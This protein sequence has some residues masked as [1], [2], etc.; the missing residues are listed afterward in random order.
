VGSRQQDAP[1]GLADALLLGERP[2]EGDL[3]LA[4]TGEAE[5]TLASVGLSLL[6]GLTPLVEQ[7]P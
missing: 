2:G 6:G 5:R 4:N 7:P 1:G 3:V